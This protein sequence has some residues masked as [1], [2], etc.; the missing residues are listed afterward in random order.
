M[1]WPLWVFAALLAGTG[2]MR[3]VE[4]AVSVRRLRERPEE[5]VAEPRLFP[6]MAVLH[7]A[8]VVAPM[9]EVLYAERP[10]VP[11]MAGAAGLVLVLAT[12]LRIWTL[13]TIGGAWNVRV[14]RPEDAAIATA[15]PYAYIRH[16]NYLCVVLEI[17]ALPL[18][19]T[20][21]ISAIAL[22]VG[23]AAVLYVRIRNEEA[24]LMQIDAWREAFA[25]RARLIPGVL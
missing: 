14:V 4:L 18:L 16:P 12:A 21:W 8:L 24:M 10:F 11:W 7:L 25:G 5:V 22:S 3:L 15:G 9:G 19:H 1:S 23:N 13:R 6:V 20:A 2:L 17:A